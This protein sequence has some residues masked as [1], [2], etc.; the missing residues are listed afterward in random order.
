ME[1][2][3]MHETGDPDVL[4]LEE[5]EQPEP[6]EGEVL[7]RVH[8]SSVNPFDWKQRRGMAEVSLPAVLGSDV[9]GVVESSRASAVA[10]G[11]EVFG[12]APSG[13][14]A[15]FAT[16]PAAVIAKKPA[17][18]SHEQAAAIPVAG[19]TAWQA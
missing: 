8:S 5:V 6:S 12:L 16:A 4:R 17:G 7:I 2:A 11:D 10:E 14:Y 9:S 19:L 3:V 1:A 15:Q 18:V 13:G